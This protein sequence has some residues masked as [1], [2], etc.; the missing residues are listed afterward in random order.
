MIFS[1]MFLVLVFSPVIINTVILRQYMH[2]EVKA[3]KAEVPLR[4]AVP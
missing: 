1:A 4:N 2:R 3:R